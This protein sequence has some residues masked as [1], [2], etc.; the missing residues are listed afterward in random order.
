M[1][2]LVLIL[3]SA[4]TLTAFAQEPN[5]YNDSQ[6]AANYPTSKFFSGISY[7]T[8]QRGE[9]EGKAKS[10]VADA[11][12]LEAIKTIRVQV[13][14]E[15]T[16]STQSESIETLDGWA[17]SVRESL[18]SKTTTKVDLEIPGL[19]TESWRVPGTNDV[20]GF[21]YIKKATL[22]RQMDKQVTAGLT[23]IE[24]ILDNADQQ[25]SQGQKT[26]A[27]EAI[28]KAIPLF[29]EVE[30]AQ[31][32]LIAADPLSDAESL[33][34]DETKKLQQRYMRMFSELKN[35]INIY[36]VCNAQLFNGTYPALKGE[37][38]GE[39]SKL[40]CTFV[41][42]AAQSDWAVYVDAA[43]REFNKSTFGDYTSYFVYVDA[44]I[45]IDKTATGQ[46]I[47]EEQLE[48]VKGA[49]TTNFVDA[50]RYDGYKQISPIISKTIK[51][52]I[53]Q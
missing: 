31:R 45:S 20:A 48:P 35:G 44:K 23:R 29:Q 38:Q 16:M 3:L 34:L 25:I 11:A 7:G 1:K 39:L 26:Q 5:W 46:R 27:R 47:Y 53:Q 2:K 17:E 42:S 43:A 24:T 49:W 30:Q 9:D 33:Q 40:G 50:A 4:M 22:S 6:R 52:H 18:D 8:I 28:K 19:Q 37:I 13:Q 36:L 15:T 51:E 10:R 21:A 14:N 32:I 12:R 41:N